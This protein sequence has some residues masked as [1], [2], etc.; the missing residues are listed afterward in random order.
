[1]LFPTI[2]FALFFLI[3]YGAYWLLASHYRMRR[4]LLLFAS[5]VFYAW[6]NWKFSL[7]LLTASLI[8]WLC[9]MLIEKT[10]RKYRKIT[11]AA[12]VGTVLSI[13]I[14]FKYYLL[15][16]STINSLTLALSAGT[17]LP[18]FSIILPVG[19]S[20]YTFQAISYMI[21]VYRNDI[22]ADKNPLDVLLYV[23]FF[24]QLV[25]GPI[26]RGKDF[27]PQLQNQQRPKIQE[28]NRA[29]LLI[30][31]GLFKKMII[32]T[33]LG[34]LLVDP[35][36][37][38][39]ANYNALSC[40]LASYAY[41]FQIF[42][43]FS[44]Y[45]DIAIGIALLFGF[46]FPKNFDQPYQAL[47]VQDFW[48]RWHISLSSWLRDYLYI[49]LGGNR[50]GQLRTYI[51]L[52]LTMLLGGL[53]HGARW[54]FVVW[55]TM[56]GFALIIERLWQ[57]HRGRNQAPA[58]LNSKNFLKRIAKRVLVFHFICASWIVF[59]LPDLAQIKLYFMSLLGGGNQQAQ[60]QISPFLILLL[61]LSLAM[62]FW[63][64]NL[65]HKFADALAVEAHPLRA[66][67]LLGGVLAMIGIVSPDGV[68]PFIYF[69][70]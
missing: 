70:F 43:D 59:R 66:S 50:R 3:T 34:T 7:L 53:W 18:I 1:M 9:A 61:L 56:H 17:P 11:L 54:T 28:A 5:Y 52:F 67:L 27:I 46:H 23:A 58:Q 30:T 68:A 44:A 22:Q 26:V 48:H 55:G 65:M 32:A 41:A 38:N 8:A 19:I 39:P 36:F 24:P 33:Y 35:V 20:F 49:P 60:T 62:H 29:L 15:L 42:C 6:W 69:Q 37:S 51:N 2:E 45:S 25:A 4:L 14:W 12:G 40:L 63:P 57:Q 64:K 16:A 47:S 13:L 10:K 31:N 21:D